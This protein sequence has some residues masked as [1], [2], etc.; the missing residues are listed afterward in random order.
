MILVGD[1]LADATATGIMSL[2]PAPAPPFPVDGMG[3]TQDYFSGQ[4]VSVQWPLC[5]D[6]I[7]HPVTPQDIS[8]LL[9]NTPCKISISRLQVVCAYPVQ[10]SHKCELSPIT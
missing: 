5:Y 3:F 4:I 2:P 1:M 7:P 10:S 6:L 8:D 9:S